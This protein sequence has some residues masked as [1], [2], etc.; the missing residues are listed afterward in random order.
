MNV[1]SFLA[2]AAVAVLA[3]FGTA[4][5]ANMDVCQQSQNWDARV[6]ACTALIEGGNKRGVLWATFFPSRA[7]P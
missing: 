1:R 5:A 2:A 4:Q 6:K 7:H 3:G